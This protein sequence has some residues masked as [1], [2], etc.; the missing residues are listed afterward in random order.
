MM[1]DEYL[2][3]IK[4]KLISSFAVNSFLIVKEKLLPESGYFRARLTLSNNDFLEVVEYFI[5]QNNQPV[6]QSYRYQW[7]DKTRQNLRKRWDNAEH[8]PGLSNFPHHVHVGEESNVEPGY[9]M[10]II[11]LI[12]LIESEI[13][14]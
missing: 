7:M 1:A 4:A 10:N 5:I 9:L 12:E 8:F 2:A 6:T 13:I 11:E 14:R 3:Q